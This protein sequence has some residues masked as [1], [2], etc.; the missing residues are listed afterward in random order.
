[1]TKCYSLI[2]QSKW[3]NIWSCDQIKWRHPTFLKFF[4]QISVIYIHIINLKSHIF[5]MINRYNILQHCK[6]VNHLQGFVLQVINSFA[7]LQ[8][9]KDLSST[10]KVSVNLV[11]LVHLIKFKTSQFI[12]WHILTNYHSD[13]R[14]HFSNTTSTDRSPKNSPKTV[15]IS[16]VF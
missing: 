13:C 16:R 5:S 11:L 9:F 14:I 12:C 7:M 4:L 3:V 15:R 2:G 8:K 6:T 10:C 1:M